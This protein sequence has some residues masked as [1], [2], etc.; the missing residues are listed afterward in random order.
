MKKK[1]TVE[2]TIETEVNASFLESLT[3]QA[4]EREIPKAK[5]IEVRVYNQN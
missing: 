1:I 2:F 3:K 4:V 5:N